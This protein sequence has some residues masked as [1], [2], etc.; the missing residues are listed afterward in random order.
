MFVEVVFIYKF[1]LSVNYW[2][3]LYSIVQWNKSINIQSNQRFFS[4]KKKER[5]EN[6]LQPLPPVAMIITCLASPGMTTHVT[7]PLVLPGLALGRF[8]TSARLSQRLSSVV[9][10][11]C[12]SMLGDSLFLVVLFSSSSIIGPNQRGTFIAAFWVVVCS[13]TNVTDTYATT[14]CTIFAAR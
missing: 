14:K 12:S 13:Y 8:R 9:A 11:R 4:C 2:L 5:M 10:C 6:K 3:Y 7:S 1:I